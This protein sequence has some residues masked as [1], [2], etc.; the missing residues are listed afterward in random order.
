MRTTMVLDAIEMARWSRGKVLGGLR[1]DDVGDQLQ[2]VLHALLVSG[3]RDVRGAVAAAL[4]SIRPDA[5]TDAELWELMSGNAGHR[6]AAALVVTSRRQPALLFALAS[7]AFDHEPQV[8][9]MVAN[10]LAYWIHSGHCR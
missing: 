8:R 1:C 4:A 10:C 3:H 9:A 5:I 7:L 2:P 6:A